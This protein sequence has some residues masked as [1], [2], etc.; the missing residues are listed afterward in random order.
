MSVCCKCSVLLGRGLC[1]G[2]I[3]RLEES[4]RLWDFVMCDLET[5]RVRSPWSTGGCR[6][7][8]RKKLR[9]YLLLFWTQYIYLPVGTEDIEV[10]Y[11]VCFH[12]R[13]RQATNVLQPAGLL[14][15]PLWTFQLWPPDVPAPTDA[16]R[17]PAAGVWT[18]GREI[19]TGNLA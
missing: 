9:L 3:I 6:F 4:Y 19:R 5:S 11:F 16:F 18:Y 17:T 10:F 12:G 7:K 2:L 14:Y 15:H 8:K 13:P 1:D